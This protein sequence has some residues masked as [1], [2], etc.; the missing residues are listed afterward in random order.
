MIIVKISISTR[1]WFDKQSEVAEW[2]GIKNSSKKAL[3][4]RARKLNFEIEFD[5]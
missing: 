1:R 3:L 2:L 4:A 5:A